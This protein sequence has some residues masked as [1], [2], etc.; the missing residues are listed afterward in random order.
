MVKTYRSETLTQVPEILM[1]QLPF[2]NLE[3]F[4]T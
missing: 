3:M 2:E 4:Q 1:W